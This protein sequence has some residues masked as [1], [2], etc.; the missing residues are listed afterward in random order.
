M[1]IGFAPP[2]TAIF[3]EKIL[4]T[5]LAAGFVVFDDRGRI[6]DDELITGA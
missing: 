6:A 5:G 2:R 3:S 1:T 4:V